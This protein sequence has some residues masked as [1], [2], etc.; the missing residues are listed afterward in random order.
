MEHGKICI[1]ERE[2]GQGNRTRSQNTKE[3]QS[4]VIPAFFELKNIAEFFA[5]PTPRN[6]SEN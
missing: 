5:L 1:P 2:M 3:E 4:R 6:L